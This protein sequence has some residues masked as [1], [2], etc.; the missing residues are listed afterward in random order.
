[1]ENE[2][3]I[4]VNETIFLGSAKT[5]FDGNL[6][7]GSICINDILEHF[8]N[9]GTETETGKQFLPIEVCKRKSPDDFG[10]THFI[11]LNTWK[12]S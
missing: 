5:L 4:A 9:Y 3:T 1:M 8:K 2:K 7:K 11:K 12:K 6:I 10:N